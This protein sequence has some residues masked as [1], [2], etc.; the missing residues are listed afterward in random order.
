MPIRVTFPTQPEDMVNKVL[1]PVING[2]NGG[3]G[4]IQGT[5]NKASGLGQTAS[6]FLNQANQLAGGFA[7]NPRQMLEPSAH[8]DLTQAMQGNFSK[9]VTL[10]P[11]PVIQ[12][13]KNL[14]QTG[15]NM[16]QQ[17]KNVYQTAKN[18]VT[19]TRGII[20][21]ALMAACLIFADA[22]QK[23]AEKVRAIAMRLKR[24]ILAKIDEIKKKIKEWIEE[25]IE[26]VI[27]ALPDCTQVMKKVAKEFQSVI[28]KVSAVVAKVNDVLRK[29]A[30]CAALA[31]GIMSMYDML[32]G[33]MNNPSSLMALL[34]KF[35]LGKMVGL[36]KDLAKYDSALMREEIKDGILEAMNELDDHTSFLAETSY[37]PDQIQD[38][39][40]E[41]E[42]IAQ[43][44]K[45]RLDNLLDDVGRD[46]FENDDKYQEYIHAIDDTKKNLDDLIEHYHNEQTNLPKRTMDNIHDMVD[47]VKD[48]L[49]E[50]EDELDK[51]IDEIDRDL[52]DIFDN[53]QKIADEFDTPEF[54][55]ALIT[56]CQ[57]TDV[58]IV[59]DDEA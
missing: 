20:S 6:G 2:F 17:A 36:S 23:F 59:I 19:T 45:E 47:G 5:I 50:M 46:D 30:Q 16:V 48:I 31:D 11:P 37:I 38:A 39:M 18:M 55:D 35:G 56:A 52:D 40:K 8:I 10:S 33:Y 12:Q 9:I 14:A 34:D 51:E 3:I 22:I 27:K 57:N 21:L 25:A 29:V 7:Q 32:V 1:N 4:P 26:A 54:Q 13:A 44:Q 15:K 28:E 43:E 49:K 42:K 24:E 58:R 53:L 41:L